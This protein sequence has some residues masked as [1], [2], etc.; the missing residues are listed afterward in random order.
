MP[1]GTVAL[2]NNNYSGWVLS[3]ASANA[4]NL[5]DTIS[6]ALVRYTALSGSSAKI[7]AST[8]ITF[9]S[10]S[11]VSSYDRGP[12]TL[13]NASTGMLTCGDSTGC[14]ATFTADISAAAVDG[15]PAGNYADTLTFTLT[16]KN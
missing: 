5:K 2:Q 13:Y 15:K 8:P 7:G 10:T 1:F 9:S 14:S 16:N 11:A 4:G 12:D 6:G 3:V